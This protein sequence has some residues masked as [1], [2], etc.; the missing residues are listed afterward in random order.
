MKYKIIQN[1]HPTLRKVAAPVTDFK[2]PELP[3]LIRDMKETMVENDG[4]GLAA[5]QIDK[6]IALFVTLDEVGVGGHTIFINPK[7]LSTSKNQEIEEEGCL[8]FLGDMS[9]IHRPF[10]VTISAQDEQEKSFTVTGEGL[11]AR[12]FLHE[13]DHLNGILFIDHLHEF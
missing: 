3:A 12:V 6:S 8:S 1:P 4:W 7:I 5:P 11:A 9:D 10:Q 13:T 2:D